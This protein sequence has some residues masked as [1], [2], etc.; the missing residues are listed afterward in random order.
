MNSIDVKKIKG[1]LESLNV[2]PRCVLR[3]LG[4]KEYTSF[5]SRASISD[6]IINN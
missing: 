2:C 4:I 1:F 5:L 6:V 3:F